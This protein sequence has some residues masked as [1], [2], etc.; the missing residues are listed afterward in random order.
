MQKY[1]PMPIKSGEVL[2]CI[3]KNNSVHLV[4][5]ISSLILK[6]QKEKKN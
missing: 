1:N 2:K 5:D 4:Q 6:K 3:A